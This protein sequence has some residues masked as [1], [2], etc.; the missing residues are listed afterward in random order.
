MRRSSRRVVEAKVEAA[1]MPPEDG[2]EEGVISQEEGEDFDE[3][4]FD[5]DE[6]VEFEEE[7]E[8]DDGET[9]EGLD[10][11]WDQEDDGDTKIE[12]EE[13]TGSMSPTDALLE[14]MNDVQDLILKSSNAVPLQKDPICY[15][16]GALLVDPPL[17]ILSEEVL[18]PSSKI[19]IPLHCEICVRGIHSQCHIS[20]GGSLPTQEESFVCFHCRTSQHGGKYE[21]KAADRVK[22][23][24]GPA[25]QAPVIPEIFFASSPVFVAK[26]RFVQI[27]C[28]DA[29]KCVIPNKEEI[30][31]FLQRAAQVW[32]DRLRVN[33]SGGSLAAGSVRKLYLPRAAASGG[34]STNPALLNHYWCP[35]SP[36]YALTILHKCQY[37]TEKALAVIKSPLLRDCFGSVCCPPAKPYYNKWKPKDRRWRMMK[38]PFPPSRIE[39]PLMDNSSANI[40]AAQY[41]SEGPRLRSR[42]FHNYY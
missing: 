14:S 12:E 37:S 23:S 30:H 31:L 35:F 8:D 5:E 11:G 24:V 27:W 19:S 25:H 32:P 9:D 39:A 22:V 13:E 40:Y 10:P 18:T 21:M 38:I 28:A 34:G 15:H 6:G 3:E 20:L 36:E 17:R 4:E 41:E 33:S 42:R 26:K 29:A 7:Q 2:E 1:P 16:C